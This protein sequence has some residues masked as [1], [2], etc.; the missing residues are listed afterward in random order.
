MAAASVPRVVPTSVFAATI[1]IDL[2]TYA[3]GFA[4]A[5]RP[6]VGMDDPSAVDVNMCCPGDT[7]TGTTHKNLTAILLDLDGNV[8][9]I[10][11]KARKK[12]A[13]LWDDGKQGTVMYFEGFKMTMSP[14][15]RGALSPFEV[16]VHAAGINQKKPLML[17]VSKF[18]HAVRVDALNRLSA[19]PGGDSIRPDQIGWVVTVPAIWDDAAKGFMRAA[20]KEA[21]IIESLDSN[22]MVLVLE[23]EGAAIASMLDSAPAVREKFAIGKRVMILDCGGGTVD[24][25]VSEIVSS[26]PLQLK[27]IL[28]ADGGPWGGTYVDQNFLRFV[29][30]LLG[31]DFA[32]VDHGTRVEL[33]D[34]WEEVKRKFDPTKPETEYRLDFGNVERLIPDG[35][36]KIDSAVARIN[37]ARGWTREADAISRT[38]RG[39]LIMSAA[40]LRSFFDPLVDLTIQKVQGM[41]EQARIRGQDVNFILLVG[42]FAESPY[43]QQRVSGA[44]SSRAQVII[45]QRPQQVVNK[46]A[47]QFGLYGNAFISSRKARMTY[48]VRIAEEWDPVR[49]R[50]F[51]ALRFTVE[52]DPT[53]YC[54]A[55]LDPLVVKGTDVSVDKPV[56]R[57]GLAPM[58]RSQ[59]TVSV[60]IYAI[61]AEIAEGA[62]PFVVQRS[63]VAHVPGAIPESAKV[64]D[65]EVRVADSD[66]TPMDDRIVDVSLFFGRSEITATALARNT[67][68]SKTATINYQA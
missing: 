19:L 15:K 21:G 27:E 1:S 66:A 54:A 16:Q 6:R 7:A 56:Q 25:T 32:A 12:F 45:P 8:L 68:D 37:A 24:I 4:L 46:G 44:F 50:G 26:R 59:H 13:A 11:S 39:H 53:P 3:S 2:G 58:E 60:R 23:P 49:H 62:Q 35:S 31:A 43:L 65:V 28:P 30:E 18:L 48:C 33:L 41:L 61:D 51:E 52:G 14:Q 22:Q 63:D 29:A 55:V 36:S 42:G 9:E 40:L 20:A 17:P 67:G 5:F 34:A 47:A 10:G 38:R 64:C 57:D